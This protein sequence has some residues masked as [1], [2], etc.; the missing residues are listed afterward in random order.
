M[1]IAAA[2]RYL[3]GIT[4]EGQMKRISMMV[5]LCLIAACSGGEEKKAEETVAASMAAGQWEVASEVTSFR[6]ADKAT[7][8][9]KAAVGDKS[10]VAGCIDGDEPPP[11]LFAGEGYDCKYKNS[12]IRNGRINASLSCKREALEGEIMMSVQGSYTGNSFDGTVEATSYLPGEGDFV[13]NSKIGGR[14]TGPT[15][16]AAP[17]DK[18]A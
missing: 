6:S 18:A 13:M 15:C 17:E 10:Q 8:A 16:Q 3:S 14:H 2:P 7:P 1:A 12:Y 11:E 5:P 4:K 9:L